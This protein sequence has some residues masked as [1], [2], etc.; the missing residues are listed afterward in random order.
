MWRTRWNRERADT[1]SATLLLYLPEGHVSAKNGVKNAIKYKNSKSISHRN[2]AN[3]C[4]IISSDINISRRLSLTRVGVLINW[5][6]FR[7]AMLG[8]DLTRSITMSMDDEYSVLMT[9]FARVLTSGF[10]SLLFCRF[11]R[12][13][14]R[15][16]TK[17]YKV[18][19]YFF[20]DPVFFTLYLWSFLL[21][22]NDAEFVIYVN[23]AFA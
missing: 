15:I 13:H 12:A 21:F 11:A 10:D 8:L 4:G 2:E 20:V 23:S 9:S 3:I 18:F 7:Q 19:L 17:I 22:E 6:H 1:P 5:R 16:H 14:T